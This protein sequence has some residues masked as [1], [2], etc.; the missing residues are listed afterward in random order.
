LYG[1]LTFFVLLSALPSAH[2]CKTPTDAASQEKNDGV[3]VDA[4]RKGFEAEKAGFKEG[5]VLLHWS[6]G[7]ANGDLESPFDLPDIE[8][9]QA[10]R[11][12]VSLEGLRDGVKQTW[13]LGPSGWGLTVR[14][15]LTG[16]FLTD[17]LEGQK[18]ARAGKLQDAAERW[19]AAN[20]TSED[21]PSWL[22]SWFLF[23]AAQTLANAKQ[24]KEADSIYAKALES[25]AACKP[26]I[27]AELLE[28]LADTFRQRRDWANAEKYYQQAANERQK[29]STDSLLFA[30]ILCN[31]AVSIR[32]SDDL[33]RPEKYFS[34]CLE[35]ARKQAP[36]SIYVAKSL[37]GL[38]NL[39]LN[40]G[41]LSEAEQYHREALVIK[42][43]LAPGSLTVAT[44]LNQLGILAI[45]RGDLAKAENY[46]HQAFTIQEEKAP[47]DPDFASVLNNLGLVAYHRGDLMNAENYYRQ[48]LAVL[49]KL[50][51]N[52]IE[53]ARD[54]N[55]LGTVARARGDLTKAEEYQAKALA[56]KE[57]LVPH[58]LDVAGT[59]SNLG[60]IARD[61]GDLAKAEEY[62]RQ[63]LV[64]KEKLAP[65]SITLAV[66][67]TNLGDLAEDRDDLVSAE[68]YYHRAL[69]IFE[70]L[71][72][73]S[74]YYG[75]TLAALSGIMLRKQQL[76]DA[77]PL[78]EQAL[79]VLENQMVH[80]GGTNEDRSRFRAQHVDHYQDYID[81]LMR[82]KQPEKALQVLERSR[83]QTLLE[84]LAQAHIDVHRG[85]DAAL[86]EREQSLRADLQAK[87]D[88]RIRLV[89][90]KHTEEQTATLNQEIAT[91]L[92][93]QNEVEGQIRSSSPS[94]AA[95]TQ[96]QPL[97]LKEIQ[98]LLDADTVLLEYSLGKERSYVFAVT[99]T[100]LDVYELAKRTEIDA[101]ARQVYELL[102]ARNHTEETKAHN[103]A[104]PQKTEAEYWQAS[105]GLSRMILTPVAAQIQG[106]RLLIVS[107]SA[108]QYIPFAALT[109]PKAGNTNKT[110]AQVQPLLIEHE[111]VNLPSASVLAVLRQERTGRKEATKAVAV[112]ADPVF[113]PTDGRV[114]S[115]G[116][117]RVAPKN[118]DGIT[119]GAGAG[120]DKNEEVASADS[121]LNSHLT[122]SV[123][124]VGLSRDGAYLPRLRFSRREAEAIMAVT[125]RG[126][127]RKALDFEANRATATS[128]DL[129]QYRVVHF[130]THG[131]LDSEHPELSGLVFSLVDE[132]GKPQNGFLELEDIY[133]LNLPVELVVLSACE[134]GLGKEIQG[135]GLVGLTRG[136]MYAG[137]SRV[138]A[139]LWSVDDVATAELMGRFYKA[140]EKDGLRPAA[141]LRKAQIEMW[142]QKD[143]NSPYYW[144]AFQLQGEW[145]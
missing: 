120:D 5:D 3:V 75:E 82:Q 47:D 74:Y 41:D 40:R 128:P 31:L 92:A 73:E 102:T 108:L 64:I 94:Y 65:S 101:A 107:D 144:A 139:S 91:L 83:A 106:R 143:W 60:N 58:S 105:A 131:M 138:M 2:S 135:E 15:N 136:F 127:G 90:G 30:D 118:G 4:V 132:K 53:V 61:R 129:A 77:A 66:S 7:D 22:S 112:L 72:P 37:T 123:S 137:A 18:L 25:C 122:R 111:I 52:S 42:E 103:S 13:I 88:H 45:R 9:E 116:M 21:E 93:Q 27:K 59:L 62:G 100:S 70:K 86:F 87:V 97:S 126:Q 17:Y 76:D 43:K 16:T 44:S 85:V 81:L 8:I 49:E 95:L 38:G 28:A 109:E 98:Q 145:K 141:A 133:N 125:P 96:P 14:P 56:L 48:S 46:L 140:M 24:W 71:A 142:K 35:I 63:A 12:N 55:N 23:H 69:L 115:A 10:S 20:K 33:A 124:D 11:G 51:P 89:T 134:T 130:A 68:E 117:V 79:H 36:D 50:A 57:N 121:H 99:A 114:S 6:R 104:L 32:N 19:R 80:L 34:Q 67:L 1:I 84:T 26:E 78:F 113:A 119:R 54:F 29:S 110:Y 39:A